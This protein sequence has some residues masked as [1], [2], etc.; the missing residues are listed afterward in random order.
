MEITF[1]SDT[2]W[3]VRDSI[4]RRDMEDLL[5]G[6]P[7]LVHAGDVSG[8]GTETE[9]RQF[10]DWFSKLPYMHKVLIAGNHDFFF[11]VAKPEEVA[12]LISEYPGI[13]YLNDSGATIEGIKFWGSPVTPFFHNW[14]FNRWPDEIKPHWDMIPEEVDVLITH[15]P[16]KGILDYTE[17]DRDNVGC[18]LLLE[19]V[20]QVKPKVHVFGHIHEARGKKEID[21]TVFINASVVTLRYELRYEMPYIVNVEPSSQNLV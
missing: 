11:E 18:S 7:I 12:A 20:K 8:R 9:I 3:L 1:I 13:T 10:L 16:P 5:P 2:H 4:D 21:D 19:K 6:G 17:Y 15:G 14:A